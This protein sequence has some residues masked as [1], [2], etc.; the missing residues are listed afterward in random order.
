MTSGVAA[1]RPSRRAFMGSVAAVAAG[2]LTASR[3]AAQQVVGR[4][5]IDFHCHSMPPVM[6]K[7]LEANG[8]REPMNSWTL[9]KHLEDMERGGVATSLLSIASP[10]I[11]HGRDVGAIRGIAREINEYNAKLTVDHPRRFGMFALLPLPDVDGSLR[12]VEYALDVLK[13]DGVGMRTPYGTL[14]HGEPIFEPLYQEL[15]RRNAVVFTHPQDSPC[16][17]DIIPG[18]PSQSTIEYGTHTTRTILSLLES[19][20][21]VRY[22]NIR[23]VFAHAGGT[24]PFLVSRIVGRKLPVGPDGMIM[25]DPSD[26]SRNS[27]QERLDTLRRFYYETAQQTN[28]V[29]L[30]ALRR[31]VPISQI[32]FGTDYPA[33]DSGGRA[34]PITDHALGLAGV[35]SGDELRAVESENALK[36]F[37][38]YRG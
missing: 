15:N 1:F 5:R 9:S 3:P 8:A 22:P 12:E 19:R 10:G 38:K 23:W 26:R 21:A 13:A 6:R 2:A 24:M 28:V 27:G 17:Q 29:A 25:L 14:W 18:V 16:C 20:M 4:H 11:W 7:F 32:V 35:F 31:V 34:A 36:L 30:G 33:S 37:P